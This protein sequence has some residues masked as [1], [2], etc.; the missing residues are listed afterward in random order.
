MVTG[1]CPKCGKRLS[2][3]D[4]LAGRRVRCPKCGQTLRLPSAPAARSK[5]I[6]RKRVNVYTLLSLLLGVGAL[7]A[8]ILLSRN[9]P[10]V[11]LTGLGVLLGLIGLGVALSRRGAGLSLALI[12]T[13]VCGSSF[14]VGLTLA[15]GV[16]GITRAAEE[17]LARVRAA[18]ATEIERA[19]ML[20]PGQEPKNK[21]KTAE[22]HEGGA[23]EQTG[24]AKDAKD[25]AQRPAKHSDSEDAVG[26]PAPPTASDI[27]K[28]A[29][30]ETQ[31]ASAAQV[32]KK[33][34]TYRKTAGLQPV[35]LDD[36]RTKACTAHARYLL[37][38]YDPEAKTR[39]DM[40]DEDRALPGYSAEGQEAAK[41]S[42]V[43]FTYGA[44]N[45]P[46]QAIDM[47]MA[48]LFHRLPLLDPGLKSVGFGSATGAND[49]LFS[50]VELARKEKS[51][52]IV[53][54][55]VDQQKDVPP[56]FGAPEH[57]DPIPQS[58][59]KKAGCP[60]TVMFPA[61]MTVRSVVATLEAADAG[62]PVDVWLSTPEKPAASEA[63]QRNT[64]CLIAKAPL[65]P[66]TKYRVKIQARVKDKPWEKS[67]QFTTGKE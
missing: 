42:L 2:A 55:P 10:G 18:P 48:S 28:Q 29:A 66:H 67:W 36:S 30:E 14:Y 13:A 52:Q 37:Q 57:P 41:A 8:A 11:P 35:S 7:P 32:L 16:E 15:G 63:Y 65:A 33:L 3:V 21:T 23:S 44:P 26:P 61:S 27:P 51:E 47:W 4:G 59:D 54:Y 22:N 64:I 43:A 6:R 56:A 9:W 17:Q 24:L 19:S 12:S 40:H 25:A 34:N 39:L 31:A 38:N 60:I 1:I 45:S 5:A 58:K 20:P 46:D 49:K 62:E 50:V 53:I